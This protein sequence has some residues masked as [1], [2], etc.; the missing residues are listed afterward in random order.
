LLHIFQRPTQSRSKSHFPSISGNSTPIERKFEQQN[1]P[2]AVRKSRIHHDPF[3]M[4]GSRQTNLI[5]I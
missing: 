4:P 1:S 5:D 2:V 3:T